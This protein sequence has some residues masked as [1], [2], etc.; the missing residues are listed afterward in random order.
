MI[1]SLTNN[2][3]RVVILTVYK[4]LIIQTFKSFSQQI[5]PT[6]SDH[7]EIDVMRKV[8]SNQF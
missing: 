8:M 7:K 6:Y 2:F 4:L 5:K 3:K 1:K